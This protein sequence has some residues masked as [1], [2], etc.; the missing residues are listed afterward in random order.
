MGVFSLFTKSNT[1][2]YPGN[3]TFFRYNENFDLYKKIFSRLRIGFR[4]IEKQISSGLP[5]LEAGYEIE[6]RKIARRNLEIFREQEI[7]DIITNSPEDYKMFLQNYSELL[8]DWNINVSNVWIKILNA[9]ESRPYLIKFKAMEVIG[10]HDNCY[11][12]RYCGVYDELRKILEFIGYEVREIAESKEKSRCCGSCGGLSRINPALSDR[13]ARERLLQFKRSGIKKI[14][15]FSMDN[16]DILKRNLEDL[17]IEVLELSDL[18]GFALG[19]KKMDREKEF[20]REE[21]KILSEEESNIQPDEELKEVR[22]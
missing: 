19:I 8:P 2:Y 5:A 18:L 3:T 20:I 16:Y 12:G 6:S 14:A 21:D 13:I 15:V 4:I 9:L 11:L 10:L 1:L 17:D 7:T 22:N